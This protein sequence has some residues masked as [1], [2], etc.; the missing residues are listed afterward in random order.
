M[1]AGACEASA[2]KYNQL[3]KKL[4]PPRGSSTATRA[5]LTSGTRDHRGT[6]PDGAR[7]V[8]IPCARAVPARRAV[9]SV[10]PVERTIVRLGRVARRSGGER[11]GTEVERG[12][13]KVRQVRPRH[14]SGRRVSRRVDQGQAGAWELFK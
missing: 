8:Y 10:A 2:T 5:E 11:G 9:S 1:K 13:D 3:A 14:G 6:S 4:Y 7:N 12:E